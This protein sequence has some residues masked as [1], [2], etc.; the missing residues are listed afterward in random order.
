MSVIGIIVSYHNLCLL[1]A[2]RCENAFIPQTNFHVLVF[3]AR[4]LMSTIVNLERTS[5]VH[6]LHVVESH[7]K[8]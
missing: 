4:E 8:G 1:C 2:K 6:A 7:S 5:E 3:V